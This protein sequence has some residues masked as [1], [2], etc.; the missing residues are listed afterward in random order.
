[1]KLLFKQ[2]FFSW[3]DSYS[4]YDEAGSVAYDVRGKLAWGHCF[5]VFSANG[6]EI[7]T[8]KQRIVSFLPRFDI[9]IGEELCG[10]IKKEFSLF[11]PKFFIDYNGWQVDGN[12]FEF[13]YTVTDAFGRHIATVTKQF[14]NFTDTYVIDVP[15]SKN[16]LA[17]LMLVLAI[18]AEK[19]SRNQHH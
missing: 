1:M 17:V 6:C 18:D 12:F 9:Y 2:K 13:D 19:C 15:D 8:V 5:K 14:F 3:L 10:T 11:K 4:I 16:A 7:G